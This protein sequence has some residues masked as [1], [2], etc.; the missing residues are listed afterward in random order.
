[1]SLARR[2]SS[3]TVPRNTM[4]VRIVSSVPSPDFRIAGSA[5]R[6]PTITL[7]VLRY[8]QTLSVVSISFNSFINITSP[9]EGGY[10]SLRSVCLSVRRITEKLV[11][12][13]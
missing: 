9:E 12:G 2:I 11:N 3:T 8:P 7:S 10:V 6:R 1:M 5:E 4:S 13:F